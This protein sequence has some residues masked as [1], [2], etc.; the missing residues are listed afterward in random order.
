MKYPD[1]Q[2]PHVIF[3]NLKPGQHI[4]LFLDYD[5][6]LADFAPNPDVVQP[7]AELVDLL[8]RLTQHPHIHTAIVSGRRLAHI[9]ALAP[10]KGIWLAGTYGLEMQTPD[11]IRKDVLDYETVRPT[12]EKLKPDWEKLLGDNQNFYLED[13]GWSL[14]IHARLAGDQEAENVLAKAGLLSEKYPSENM[15]HLLGGSKFLEICPVTA[16]KPEAI[17]FILEHDPVPDSIPVYLGDDDKD[18]LAF[19]AIKQH[20]GIPIVVAAQERVTQASYRLPSPRAVRAWLEELLEW[21]E[22]GLPTDL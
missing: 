17:D 2:P 20:G 11:G 13:K 21:L 15:L 8:S 10:I 12:L 5:G 7:D 16:A 1:I 6:T 14:A 19:A 3:A 22:R 9:I 18:E 4:W